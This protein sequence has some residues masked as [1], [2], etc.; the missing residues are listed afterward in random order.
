MRAPQ[1]AWS[2]V[3]KRAHKFITIETKEGSGEKSFTDQVGM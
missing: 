2:Q 3:T 1:T